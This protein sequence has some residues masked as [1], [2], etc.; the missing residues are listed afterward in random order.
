MSE[1]PIIRIKTKAGRYIEHELS[2]DVVTVGR[3]VRADVTI[4]D[5]SVSRIHFKLV[6]DGQDYLIVDNGSSNGTYLRKRKVVEEKQF[7]GKAFSQ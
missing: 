7:A 2:K 1:Q 4:D 6:R 5:T 3:S